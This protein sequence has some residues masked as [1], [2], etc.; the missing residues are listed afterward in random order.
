MPVYGRYD[1]FST[2]GSGRPEFVAFLERFVVKRPQVDDRQVFRDASPVCR[3]SPD[4]PPFFVLHGRDD[5]VIPVGEAREFATALRAASKS[6]V[7]YAE[8]P[9]AQHA[10][11][12]FGSPRARHSAAAIGFFL[13]WVYAT[14]SRCG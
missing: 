8:L 1:W 13:S 11:D 6:P 12:V 4:A 9:G 2:Q 3:L 7:A 5:S 10:F 14:S